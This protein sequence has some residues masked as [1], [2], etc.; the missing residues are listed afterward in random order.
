M[1]VRVGIGSWADDAYKGVLYPPGLPRAGRL[2]EYARH[3]SHVEVNATYYA[4][5]KR[6]AVRAWVQ[7]TP[8]SFTF[9]LKLHRAVA[10][11]P[12]RTVE[13]GTL[14]PRLLEQVQPLVEAGRLLC[15]F[16]V[17]P[18][19]FAPDRHRLDEL[20][21]LVQALTPHRLAVELR[22]RRWVAGRQKAE[23]L[24]YFRERK[25]VW[26]AVDMPRIPGSSLMPAVDV[27]TNPSLAYLRLH[28]R[29]PSY[30]EA[31]SA[32]EGHHYAYSSREIASLANRV[33]RLGHD[34]AEVAV[35]ANNH[36]SDFA[37][38]TALALQERL[39]GRKP[40]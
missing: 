16:L 35:I 3:F 39:R 32:A 15:F 10:T 12:A 30:L 21:A 14:V 18:P 23:T 27:A 38:R 4:L 11:S 20:D 2:G 19:S 37:P 22:D 26:I 28:G 9:S 29:N 31:G 6:E 13:K 33:R 25:L 34:A 40:Q 1:K 5:P 24:R 7:Q 17:L 8:P 36:A